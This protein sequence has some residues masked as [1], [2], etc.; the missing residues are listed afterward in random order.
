MGLPSEFSSKLDGLYFKYKQCEDCAL[1][2][3]RRTIVTGRGGV[4]ER[5]VFVVDRF[6][7]ADCRK[8]SLLTSHRGDLLRSVLRTSGVGLE[9]IWATPAV[10]CPPRDGKDAKISEVKACRPRLEQELRILQPNL[11]IGMGTNALRSLFPKDTPAVNANAGR[12]LE[13]EVQGGLVQYAVPVMVTYSLAY[14]IKNPDTSPG[15]LWNKFCDHVTKA[16]A[17]SR[18]LTSLANNEFKLNKYFT[19]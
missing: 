14:L 13:A 11:I 3:T 5:V 4:K 12:I 1:H 19:K 6:S 15:G 17:V 9:D 2:R 18:D 7:E 10:L 8:S 16:I